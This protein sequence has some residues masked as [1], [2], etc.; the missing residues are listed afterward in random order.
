MPATDNREIGLQVYAFSL[1]PEFV[2]DDP[3]RTRVII[4]A[5]G[6]LIQGGNAAQGYHGSPGL[7]QYFSRAA[8][9]TQSVFIWMPMVLTHCV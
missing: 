1:N 6:V 8:L 3:P 7:R 9:L 4:P 5:R 2:L